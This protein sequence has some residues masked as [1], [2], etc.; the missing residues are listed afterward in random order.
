MKS[1]PLILSLLLFAALSSF[2]QEMETPAISDQSTPVEEN[3]PLTTIEFEELIYEFGEIESGDKVVHIFK[4]KNTGDV[5]LIITKAKGSCGCT[6]PFYPTVPIFPG[7]TSE[8][9]VEFNSK[10]KKGMQSKRVTITA[11]TKPAQTFLTVKGQVN[12]TPEQADDLAENI[13]QRSE[14]I[15]ELNPDCFAIFPNPTSETLQ[16]RL[17]EHIGKSAVIDIHNQLGQL[18]LNESINRISSESTRFDVKNYQPGLY[19]IT[20]QVEDTKPFTQ[21]FVVVEQ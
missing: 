4:F 5:P 2:A 14:Q 19:M 8:I 9:E 13:D 20:I 15:A 10:G 16:L 12:A 17:K 18:M 3:L 11:N 7:E 1:Y 6:V 21:C